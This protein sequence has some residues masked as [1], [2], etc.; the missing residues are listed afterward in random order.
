MLLLL[1][2]R[3]LHPVFGPGGGAARDVLFRLLRHLQAEFAVD[4]GL[5]AGLVPGEL[6]ELL[7]EL[8]VFLQQ[9]V[10]GRVELELEVFAV[11]QA[12]D[13]LIELDDVPCRGLGNAGDLIDHRSDEEIQLLRAELDV[14]PDGAEG[15]ADLGGVI[16]EIRRP[17]AEPVGGRL[18][19]ILH[20]EDLVE[21]E[22]EAL[23]QIAERVAVLRESA[24]DGVGRFFGRTLITL[25][26]VGE[27][28]ELSGL[29]SL[30]GDD[31]FDLVLQGGIGAVFAEL[32]DTFDG[33]LHR[34]AEVLHDRGQVLTGR[35]G[36][37]QSNC[38]GLP[39]GVAG[40]GVHL[41]QTGLGFEHLLVTEDADALRLG[42]VTLELADGEFGHAGGVLQGAG[43]QVLRA[44]LDAG[45]IERFLGKLFDAGYGE[46]SGGC[47]GKL[48][49]QLLGA[50]DAALEAAAVGVKVDG[51]G[52]QTGHQSFSL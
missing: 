11:E 9:V 20:A 38:A 41:H 28:D 2:D 46:V 22:T 10:D 39:E 27:Q 31:L 35:R 8:L 5:S 1:L 25:L 16:P 50:G 44:L 18:E 48:L 43:H 40:D 47:G 32:P 12:R 36:N 4:R 19:Q 30:R 37:V 21:Q 13:R 15:I 3:L 24:A 29:A 14:V 7:A 52:S 34:L 42:G 26:Q 23:L 45:E 17:G 49:Q 6:V 51:E 33:V